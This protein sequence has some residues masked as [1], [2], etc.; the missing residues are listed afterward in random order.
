MALLKNTGK[1]EKVD[2][3]LMYLGIESTWDSGYFF[4]KG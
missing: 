1:Q 2:K 4:L 3:L